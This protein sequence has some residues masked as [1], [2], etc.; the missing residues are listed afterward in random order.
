ME[1]L[2]KMTIDF[3]DNFDIN[4]IPED[5]RKSWIKSYT[6]AYLSGLDRDYENVED[7]LQESAKMTETPDDE[8]AIYPIQEVIDILKEKYDFKDEQFY[9]TNFN[10]VSAFKIYDIPVFMTEPIS[11][12]VPNVY[13]NIAIIDEEIKNCGYYKIRMSKKKDAAGKEWYV[14]GYNPIRQDNIRKM[15]EGFR[16]LHL[17]P[18]FNRK[19]IYETGLVPGP[20]NDNFTYKDDRIFLFIQRNFDISERNKK[21][22]FSKARDIKKKHPDWDGTFDVYSVDCFKVSMKQEFFYDPNIKDSVY[23][24]ERISRKAVKLIKHIKF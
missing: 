17:S 13:M 19:E 23:T 15:I 2:V 22:M 20:G 8:I 5:V 7:V 6:R 14:L 4:S 3:V 12:I 21:I 10:N 18:T 9:V 11:V 16:W 1:D 24:K